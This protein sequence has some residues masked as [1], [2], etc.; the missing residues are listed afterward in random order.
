MV[1]SSGGSVVSLGGG[2]IESGCLLK[3][4]RP[5]ILYTDP[6]SSPKEQHG[7]LGW[8]RRL[9]PVALRGQ[10]SSAEPMNVFISR[11]I[12]RHLYT[13]ESS[14]SVTL[15]VVARALEE[16][17]TRSVGE[18]EL[19]ASG[20]GIAHRDDTRRVDFIEECAGS[21]RR[22]D[23]IPLAIDKMRSLR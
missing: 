20:M 8:H 3:R 15:Q 9:R 12:R 13:N 11:I 7:I 6:P 1:V 18:C 4:R 14:A 23:Q 19:R 5:H 16:K 10:I 21:W 2:S 22:S 17:F